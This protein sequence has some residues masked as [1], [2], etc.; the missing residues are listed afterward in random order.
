[1]TKLANDDCDKYL[2]T[3]T[4]DDARVYVNRAGTRFPNDLNGVVCNR[5]ITLDP[6]NKNAYFQKCWRG[7]N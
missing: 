4:L 3:D 5:A 1:M 2:L 7:D 6:N